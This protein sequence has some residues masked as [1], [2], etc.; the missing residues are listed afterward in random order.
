VTQSPRRSPQSA[1]RD[2]RPV[3]NSGLAHKKVEASKSEATKSGAGRLASHGAVTNAETRMSGACSPTRTGASS[4][5]RPLQLGPDDAARKVRV[6][7]APPGGR[8]L[9]AGRWS[10]AS[11]DSPAQA[12]RPAARPA[13]KLAVE[14]GAPLLAADA[15]KPSLAGQSSLAEMVGQLDIRSDVDTV[16]LEDEATVEEARRPP[17]PALPEPRG[18]R[19]PAPPLLVKRTTSPPYV[20]SA[21]PGIEPPKEPVRRELS[22]PVAAAAA[23]AAARSGKVSLSPPDRSPC[24]SP[25]DLRCYTHAAPARPAS[26]SSLAW[27]SPSNPRARS[28]VPSAAKPAPAPM[29]SCASYW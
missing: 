22:G 28:P 18:E 3:V 14:P 7:T 8:P 16:R 21:V 25:R 1:Y 11:L 23:A 9:G 10:C 12:T 24:Q 17:Q 27:Q 5:S 26:T 13:P 6:G 2:I 15:E 20:P 19:E 4:P 29:V